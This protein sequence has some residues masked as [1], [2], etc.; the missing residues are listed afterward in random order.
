MHFSHLCRGCE[1]NELASGQGGGT[2]GRMNW[3]Q[4]CADKSLADLPYKIE[5]NRQGQ[6]IMSPSRSKHSI[7]QGRLVR[8]LNACLPDGEAFPECAMDTSD[9]VKVPDVVWASSE[10]L[11][12]N[13]EVITWPESPEIVVE[14]SS[15]SN[16][17]DE[18]AAKRALYFERG[19]KEV[20]FCD[21]AGTMTFFD[22]AGDLAISRFCPA[23]PKSIA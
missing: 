19:A 20:W 9:G 2:V 5:L 6:I 10:K 4:V 21:E 15:D 17:P 22:A 11:Q 23:F 18:M 16:T 13:L 8:K 7:Y 12:R 3:Q 1:H 14:I